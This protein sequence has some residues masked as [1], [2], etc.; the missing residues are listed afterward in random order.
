MKK[1]LLLK[2]L[3]TFSMLM[4]FSVGWLN[5][6]NILPNGNME[7][8]E[9]A[10]TP[11]TWSHVE[12]IAQEASVVHGDTYSAK[13][14]GGTKDL[15]QTI[16]VNPNTEYKIIIWYYVESGDGSDARIWSYFKDGSD[17]RLADIPALLG[18]DNGYLASD[19]SWQKYETTVTSPSDA[20]SLYFEV[21]TYSG[22]VVYW[23]DMSVTLAADTDAP[24]WTPTYPKA[25]NITETAFDLTVNMDEIGTAYYV[26]VPD[27]ADAPTPAE[28]KAGVD[29]GT[30]TLVNNGS[31]AVAAATTDYSAAIS[32]LTT[33]TLYDVYL[34]AE[35]DEASPNQQAVVALVEVTPSAV[36]SLD[37]T[38]PAGG[39]ILTAG[40]EITITWDAANVTNVKMDVYVGVTYVDTIFT[41]Q[42]ATDGSYTFKIPY[43][44]ETLTTYNLLITDLDDPG[45]T[46][47]SGNFTINE[48][49]SSTIAEVQGGGNDSPLAGTIVKINGFITSN[50]DGDYTIQDGTAV[51]SGIWIESDSTFALEENLDIYGLVKEDYDKTVIEVRDFENYGTVPTPPEATSVTAAE[52]ASEDYEGM[53]V[54]LVAF[55]CTNPDLGYGEWELSD[56]IDSCRVD[57]KGYAYT[58]ELNG[59]Y[60]VTGVVDFSYGNFKLLPRDEN[61]ITSHEN[62]IL[63]FVFAEQIEDATIDADAHTVAI[64][65]GYG[66]DASA[67]TPT[68]TVSQDAT[69]SPLSGVEQDFTVPVT[70]TVTAEDGTTTQDWT[71]TVTV[72]DPN[73]ETEIVS[74]SLAEQTSPAVIVDGIVSIEVA[75]G[76]T[77]T[78]LVPTIELSYGATVVPASGAAQDFVI[79]TPVVYTVTAEDGTA[80]QEW[81]VSVKEAPVAP[82][83]TGLIFSEYIEGGGDNKAVE[84]YN[85]TGADVDL[86]NY[87]I[88]INYNGNAWNEVFSFPAGTTVPNQE[89]YVIAHADAAAEILAVTDTAV[90]N[91]YS[92]GT[93][94]MAVFSG[95][96][97]RALCKV[98]GTDTTIID[99]IGKYDLVD[100]GSGWAV[101]GVTDATK[102]HTILRKLSVTQGNV[103]WDASAGTDAD[104]SEWEVYEKDYVSDIGKHRD[105]SANTDANIETFVLDLQTGDAV[106][107]NENQTVDIEVIYDT[108]LTSLEP[109]IT[110]SDGATVVPESGIAQDFSAPVTY[111]VTAEDGIVVREWTVNV[112]VSATP[113]TD[114]N[115]V[116]FEASSQDGDAVIDSAAATVDFVVYYGTDLDSIITNFELSKGATCDI[117][118]GD[119]VNFSAT[120]TVK[121]TVT[122]QDGNNV[123]EWSVVVSE[124]VPIDASIYDIQYTSDASGDSP[125]LDEFIKTYGVVTAIED[126]GFYV[127]DSSAT[128]NG[129]YAYSPGNNA[130]IGDSVTFVATVQEYYNLTELGYVNAYTALATGVE[131]P[132]AL[133]ISLGEIMS[134][135]YEGVLVVTDSVTCVNPTAEHGIWTVTDGVDTMSV[136]DDMFSY[137]TPVAGAVYAVTGVVKYS[138]DAFVLLPRDTN[139]VVLLQDVVT[140]P[141]VIAN[142]TLNPEVPVADGAVTVSASITDDVA[143]TEV[144]LYWGTSEDNVTTSLTFENTGF[145]STYEGTIPGNAAGTT[146]YYK[147]EASDGDSTV[148][149]SGNYSIATAI[150]DFNSIIK[151]AVYPNPSNGKFNVEIN[152]EKANEMNIEIF[153]VQGQVV[154][155]TSIYNN[156]Y[157][158]EINISNLSKGI[159]YLR[160][161]DGSNVNTKKILLQ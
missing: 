90:V 2:S 95:D 15:G 100:P 70:Y 155:S 55:E 61:D 122:S 107:D 104:N 129:V 14:T 76:T 119:T 19:A 50:I 118:T 4:L 49:P 20:A 40:D 54:K 133:K 26:T 148:T 67:L 6:Q 52:A 77:L 31:I 130:V 102:D 147:I 56:G 45:V 79:G 88:R 73:T 39:E 144:A 18:P 152:N 83:T 94:Y 91:P 46:N 35:D 113:E 71:V 68:I 96:D 64:T 120:N 33:D 99:L 62:D 59:H 32:A 109:A 74:F 28:V 16:V 78:G 41:N 84:I 92:G 63:S 132:A 43:D 117:T 158:G 87:V 82:T 93:S 124:Q 127:Q 125:L 98:E 136:D 17:V 42:L 131:L 21:R 48:I 5:A 128:W 22:A 137:E 103:D 121:F 156:E 66:T 12:N 138:Y 13:H 153:N 8:W 149:V 23:D 143:V 37:I 86:A 112:T 47:N 154:Y 135:P 146:V 142:V 85:G 69:V 24:I 29:Y 108:D 116:S 25:A 139:D 7:S 3:L 134:E 10:T 159:Y 51:R 11:T 1:N 30:V 58:P 89:V 27:G 80:T 161:N 81:N 160:I 97:V 34:I 105:V 9:D 141:P 57:D 38:Y 123:R 36:K 115:I 114:A 110:V 44:A 72:A 151:V 60:D 111:S 157:K 101:A 140:D 145:G 53:L 75:N 106:I 126:D 150:N 65:V